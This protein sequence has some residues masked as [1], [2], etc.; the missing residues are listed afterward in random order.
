MRS[1]QTTVTF[2][3]PFLMS[4][5]PD[6]LPAGTH[7]LL[8]EEVSVIGPGRRLHRWTAAYLTVEGVTGKP[9]RKSRRPLNGVDLERALGYRTQAPSRHIQAVDPILEDQT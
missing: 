9:G 3:V 2:P 5:Y 8:V 6:P 1:T 7:E 4:G